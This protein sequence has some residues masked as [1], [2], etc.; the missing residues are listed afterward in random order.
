M[1]TGGNPTVIGEHVSSI[2]S[3]DAS[4]S[5][6]T[7]SALLVRPVTEG[8]THE[9]T[10]TGWKSMYIESI[11]RDANGFMTNPWSII[12]H[13]V[14][15]FVISV[16]TPLILIIWT[17]PL[18]FPGLYH[19]AP[20]NLMIGVFGF[21]GIGIVVYIGLIICECLSICSNWGGWRVICSNTSISAQIKPC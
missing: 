19:E 8:G 15:P 2:E 6:E 3:I 9:E 21:V 13:C 14:W 12:Q 18:R 10:S 7:P 20:R 1:A 5:P 16:V 11:V 17:M 4:F